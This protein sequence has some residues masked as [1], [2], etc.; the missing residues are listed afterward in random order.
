VKTIINAP[1]SLEKDLWNTPSYLASETLKARKNREVNRVEKLLIALKT[2]NEEYSVIMN[3]K[4]NCEN[5]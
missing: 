4:K 2:V 5:I 1:R 3:Q